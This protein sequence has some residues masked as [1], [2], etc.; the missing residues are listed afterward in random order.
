MINKEQYERW[1]AELKGCKSESERQIIQ[2]N[3]D[4]NKRF[5]KIDEL[6][7]DMKRANQLLEYV[8][9]KVMK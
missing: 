4:T 7:A 9:N 5:D 6:M 3:I 1:D 2:F 8:V